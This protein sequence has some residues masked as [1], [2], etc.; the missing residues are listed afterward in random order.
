PPLTDAQKKD[1]KEAD[2]K[3]WEEKAKSGL[4]ANDPAL[5]QFLIQLRTSISETVQG[6]GIDTSFD[7]L[8][9]IGISTS[10]NYQDNGK[11][12]I[13]ETK[14]KS[15]LTSNLTDIQ[16]MFSNR[17]DT[18][19]GT[20]TTVTSSIKYKNSGFAVRVYDRIADTLSRL[21]VIAGSPDTI[22]LNSNMAKAATSIDDRMVKLLDRL[23]AQEQAL[24][25]KFTA[26]ESALQ[27]LNTQ[28]SWL[29]QQLGQ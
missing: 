19:V 18:G 4:L 3:L 27:K 23:D 10:T 13:D 16:K 5:R 25:K 6:G 8:K 2:I 22:S 1:M 9:E 12:A 28:S 21:K 15:L 17:F 14:L 11:L 7:T 26:M 24:W 29:S 20:D